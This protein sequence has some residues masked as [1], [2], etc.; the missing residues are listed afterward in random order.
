MVQ[1]FVFSTQSGEGQAEVWLNATGPESD[2]YRVDSL[3]FKSKASAPKGDIDIA[4]GFVLAEDLLIGTEFVKRLDDGQLRIRTWEEAL[5]GADDATRR[6]RVNSLTNLRSTLAKLPL[7]H[8][9]STSNSVTADFLGIRSIAGVAT[10][11][12]LGLDVDALFLGA[13]N[14]ETPF[15]RAYGSAAFAAGFTSPFAGGGL[16]ATVVLE[17]ELTRRAALNLVPRIDVPTAAHLG[18][19]WPRIALPSF[20]LDKVDLSGIGQLFTLPL[21]S[22][23]G[24][25]SLAFVWKDPPPEIKIAVDQ[26]DGSATVA[27]SPSRNGQLVLKKSDGTAP[28]TI[29]DVTNASLTVNKNGVGFTGDVA[30][31]A[32]KRVR[33]VSQTELPSA[34]T[35]PFVVRLV[36]IDVEKAT[37]STGPGKPKLEAILSIGRCEVRARSDPSLVIAVSATIAIALDDGKLSSRL[38]KLDLVEPYP[39][40][41][42]AAAAQLIEDGAR[43]LWSLIQR[44]PIPDPKAPSLPGMPPLDGVIAVL[45]RLGEL[46]A[47]AAR[48]LAE[49][50][51]A[52]ARG[53]AGLAEAALRVIA[54]ALASLVEEI[55]KKA[56]Q[57]FESVVIE[58]RIDTAKWQLVQI[59]VTPVKHV[60]ST[61]PLTKEFL[62][63][64]LKVPYA[65]SPALVYDLDGHWLALVLQATGGEGEIT[66]STDLWLGRDNAP[67]EPASGAS[68]D[69]AAD[70]APLIEIR[71]GP[72]PNAT[73]PVKTVLALIVVDESGA[74][75]FQ[76]LVTTPGPKIASQIDDQSVDVID[77]GHLLLAT[78]IAKPATLTKGDCVITPKFNTQRVLSIFRSPKPGADGEGQ[79]DLAD[80][81]SQYIKVTS[82]GAPA[83]DWDKKSIKIDVDVEIT[84]VEATLKTT[85]TI[86]LNFETLSARV[87]SDKI[88]VPIKKKDREFTLLGLDARIHPLDEK[89]DPDPFDALELWF[90]D[91]NPRLQ[92]ADAARIDLSYGKLSSEGRGLK[93]EVETFVVARDGIDLAA[94]IKDDPVTLA[95]VD[96]PFRFDKGSLS[97]KRSTIQAF[98]LQGHGN[99]PPTL[100]GEAKASITLNFAERD[101]RLALQACEAVLDKSAD[102]LRCEATRFTITVTKLGL[103][104]I[105]QGDYHF[106]FTLTGS[107]QFHPNGDEFSS[108]L[109]KNLANLK[110]VLDEAPLAADPRVLLQHIEFQI[111]VEPPSRTNF[112]NIFSFELRGVGFHPA[113]PAFG[114]TPA[115][116][117]SGQVNFTDFGDVVTPRFDFHKMW[118]APPEK[119]QSLPRLRFDGLGVGLRLGSAADVYGTAVAVDGS[120]PTLLAPEVAP[121]N[122]TG[123]G[124]LASGSLQIKGWASMSASMGF[125]ELEKAGAA[126]KRH[127]FFIYVQQN[128][129][130]EKIPTPIGTIYLREVGYG[131]GFRYT[132]AG[133]AAADTTTT[134][135]Q[136]VKLLDEV[137]KY[138]GDLDKVTAWSPTYDN[139]QITLALRGL[140]SL[141]TAS[142]SDSYNQTGEAELPNLALFDIVAAL[143]TD[144]T[145][146]LNIRLWVAYNYNDW[147]KARMGGDAS[148]R[149]RPSLR[150]YMY[151]S[152][153]RSEF[154]ARAVFDPN[155]PIGDHPKL[156]EPLKKAMQ[157]ARW[158]STMYVRPGLFHMEFGWPYEL[159]FNIGEE[160]GNFFLAVEG[161]TVLRFEDFAMLY[162]LAF[163][164]RGHASFS[165]DTGGD[166]GA[167]VS[168]YAAFALSAKLIAYLSLRISESMFYGEITLDLTLQFSVRMWLRTKWFSLSAGFSM[169]ITVHIAVELLLAPAGPAGRVEASISV[170][171]FGC[172]L[173]LGIGFAFGN[174]DSLAAARARVARFLSLG[175]GVD[176]PDP[177]QGAPVSR[178]LPEPSPSETAKN[179]D[180]RVNSTASQREAAAK[181]SEP[182]LSVDTE[183]VGAAF[184]P[185][186]YWAIL[187]PVAG[188][189]DG[190]QFYLVQLLP[191]GSESGDEKPGERSQFYAAPAGAGGTYE[192]RDASEYWIHDTTLQNPERAIS[193]T[194]N[195][196]FGLPGSSP[197]AA[198][199]PQ[200]DELFATGCF[201]SKGKIQGPS[202]TEE[203]YLLTDLEPI[204][205]KEET[206]PTDPEAFNRKVADAARSRADLG[207]RRKRMQQVDETRSCFIVTVGQCAEE[208]A[209]RVVVDKD[210][211]SNLDDETL[212]VGME[213]DPRAIG[214]TFIKSTSQI[215]T[216]FGEYD[217]K[218]GLPPH[219]DNFTIKTLIPLRTPAYRDATAIALLNPPERMFNVS[220][221]RLADLE[222]R[223]LPNGIQLYWDLEPAWG[224]SV[225]AYDDPEYHLKHYRIERHISGLERPPAPRI[226]TVK[227]ADMIHFQDTANGP[228]RK[229]LKSRLQFVDDLSDLPEEVRAAILPPAN[230][231]DRAHAANAPLHHPVDIGYVIVPV[232]IAGTA[233]IATPATVRIDAAKPAERSIVRAFA[234]FDYGN[235]ICE[236]GSWLPPPDTF[237]S[238]LIEEDGEPSDDATNPPKCKVAMAYRVRVC[239]ERTV[240][241]GVFGA[242][243]LSHARAEPSVPEPRTAPGANDLEFRLLPTDAPPKASVKVVVRRLP[244]Y[245]PNY[246]APDV[247][248]Q[249]DEAFIVLKDDWGKL[250]DKL[251]LNARGPIR[252]SRLYIAPEPADDDAAMGLPLVTAQWVPVQIQ[253]RIGKDTKKAPPPIDITVDHYE[254]PMEV[255]FQAVHAKNMST[256][257]GRLH[258]YHPLPCTTF[259]DFA[260]KPSDAVRLFPDGDRRTCVEVKWNARPQRLAAI[261]EDGKPIG[262]D[263]QLLASMVGGFDLFAIDATAVPEGRPAIEYATCIGRV[264]RLPQASRG[265][266]PSETGDFARVEALY[267]SATR[268][269]PGPVRQMRRGDDQSTQEKPVDTKPRA[270]WY[271][272]AESFLVW[273][274]RVLRRSVLTL[275]DEVELGRLFE[276]AR[277]TAVTLSWNNWPDKWPHSDIKS[278]KPGFVLVGSIINDRVAFKDLGQGNGC[279]LSLESLEPEGGEKMPFGV[280]VL[281]RAL[282][283]LVLT[284]DMPAAEEQDVVAKLRASDLASVELKLSATWW[285]KDLNKA[286]CIGTA[287]M[288]SQ[289]VPALHPVLADV[290]DLI[291][292]ENLQRH[293]AGAPAYRRYEPVVES[294][295]PVNAKSLTGF[296]DDTSAD[297]DPAGWGV[298]R[299]FGLAASFRLFDR[300]VGEFL[301]AAETLKQLDSVLTIV[302]PRYGKLNDALGSPFVEVMATADALAEL[303]SFHGSAPTE[304]KAN[305]HIRNNALALV[306]CS[307]RPTVRPLTRQ[308]ATGVGKWVVRYAKLFRKLRKTLG[309]DGKPL[310][311]VVASTDEVPLRPGRE[312][313]LIELLP[314]APTTGGLAGRRC[315]MLQKWDANSEGRFPSGGSETISKT[316]TFAKD[317]AA[318]SKASAATAAKG[319]GAQAANEPGLLA[320]VRL[321]ALTSE[322]RIEDLNGIFNDE[323]AIEPL[324]AVDAPADDPVL[325]GRFGDLPADW[326]AALLFGDGLE[327][328]VGPGG[329]PDYLYPA[330]RTTLDAITEILDRRD[331]QPGTPNPATIPDDAS[332]RRDLAARLIEWSRRFM[333]HGPSECIAEGQ[334]GLALAILTRP[335]PWRVAPDPSDGRLSVLLFEKD[336]YGK[337]RKYAVKPFGRYDNLAQAMYVDQDSAG[338]AARWRELSRP[339]LLHDGTFGDSK[340]PLRTHFVDAVTERTEPLA[341]PVILAARR[342][343]VA[344]QDDKKAP[345]TRDT[346][347]IVIARHSEEILADAN[348]RTDAGIAMRHVALGFWR[349][350]AAPDWERRVTGGTIDLLEPFGPFSANASAD[351]RKLEL[352]SLVLDDKG[353]IAIDNI[354]DLYE[355]HA[356]LWRGAYV[357]RVSDMPYG[358]RFHAAAHLAAG[359]TVSPSSVASVEGS[360]FQLM[361]PWTYQSPYPSSTGWQ[362][363]RIEQPSWEIVRNADTVALSVTWPLMRLVDSMLE[364]A[365]KLWL[366]ADSAPKLYRLPDPDVSYRLSIDSDDGSA[367]VAEAEFSAI[368]EPD[369]GQETSA[370]FLAQK[371]G[372]RF[373]APVIEGV[374]SAQTDSV[375]THYRISARLELAQDETKTSGRSVVFAPPVRLQ[376]IVPTDLEVDANEP[377]PWWPIAPVAIRRDSGTSIEAT[378]VPPDVEDPKPT[379]D[380][381]HPNPAPEWTRFKQYVKDVVSRYPP[382]ADGVEERSKALAKTVF[383]GLSKYAVDRLSDWKGEKSND[384]LAATTVVKLEVGAEVWLYGL[385]MPA[386]PNEGSDKF[387][388]TLDLGE[389]ADWVSPANPK[390]AL[391]A[392]ARAGIGA[393]FARVISAESDKDTKQRLA[394]INDAIITGVQRYVAAGRRAQDEIPFA[395]LTPV[396]KEVPGDPDLSHAPQLALDGPVD[397]VAQLGLGN[398][399]NRT[400]AKVDAAFDKLEAVQNAGITLEALA[401]MREKPT[402]ARSLPLLWSAQTSVLPELLGL[403]DPQPTPEAIRVLVR[404]PATVA[405]GKAFAPA[406]ASLP[407]IIDRITTGMVL[408]P[409]RRLILNAF[410]GVKKPVTAEIKRSG[411]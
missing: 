393:L 74:H 232:D 157:I 406:Q 305:E 37:V 184:G 20:S 62:G 239:T 59:V 131:F 61:D 195:T 411:S 351:R 81:L 328:I 179:A 322:A 120:I 295:P 148:W 279:E 87:E 84:I 64:R 174:A 191:R 333:E 231:V 248:D 292:Y 106:Y 396:S 410:H 409:R 136:L 339:D 325:W 404:K 77:A 118:I 67:A 385:P 254:H 208:L 102:P 381:P 144:L 316:I 13:S 336:R 259:A 210:G 278:K 167:A 337:T 194:W 226:S 313:V 300:E 270:G 273:P 256:N 5:E 125:L 320:Y 8:D 353:D 260:N 211:N 34:L 218:S 280:D 163:R 234:R 390:V 343:D 33:V 380:N 304:M 100:V 15:F 387:K 297:R 137:S 230:V 359:V 348:I 233:G 164:A 394:R 228:I 91:G 17:V 266:D 360:D 341:A 119:G 203:E 188:P 18:I 52:A 237:L 372:Q 141:T 53:L 329:G 201:L 200:L 392:T 408:G 149:Q 349:E 340:E 2:K 272:P 268:R 161:G 253:I 251:G 298:L 302:L 3:Q 130:A 355:Q 54:D 47:A 7:K 178:P 168:A 321:V 338:N 150:G 95:G 276:K 60:A 335:T 89:K 65:F 193:T 127:A 175:L 97:V 365:R 113:A 19:V 124:F 117:I 358:F 88:T 10:T 407:G 262:A 112:F 50:G 375:D 267:P 132:L 40:K 205:W 379:Q 110:I 323:T 85:L 366:G 171:A 310:P 70:N 172:G 128:D 286:V 306:Q 309:P 32:S 75:F 51:L 318:Q 319:V 257:S 311:P 107:A 246:P 357:I 134:P 377:A 277:P 258:L 101:G 63:L 326:F 199:P 225:G 108:G 330:A 92:L 82:A 214:L 317:S 235:H 398:D 135:R 291:R 147:R 24:N 242:D 301:S 11:F 169:S 397:L 46:A 238:F 346:I 123:K 56:Q 367:R 327:P 109:L 153:P 386:Q 43:Q 382:F 209:R 58:L 224:A 315:L 303:V 250:V 126:E 383:D 122:V 236:L 80:K 190:E 177:E 344:G 115:F 121:S 94:T 244:K 198:Q 72:D 142:S 384:G 403:A 1:L 133:L 207:A 156:P 361:H 368:P 376:D 221:P 146:L 182:S 240:A 90:T 285:D 4:G 49:Q 219:S 241:S 274:R 189:S 395:G 192:I 204:G 402:L 399:D 48:W 6:S 38:T 96:M 158:S 400:T 275:P 378:I 93:F 159:G 332:K 364:S 66:L 389:I 369:Q 388:V 269:L 76:K 281:R 114:G 247:E 255:R 138:Q 28:E 104:F 170:S 12:E 103:K 243:A 334:A 176:Y 212:S 166:F 155:G 22:L 57:I 116:S 16:A 312:K 9:G 265:Q 162:G 27:T 173:S 21:P 287:T 213:F 42:V 271:S 152:V 160:R 23:A 26:G 145:F 14:P 289:L 350:F 356:D 86:F 307:L 373:R 223:V 293:D 252:G 261:S 245:L 216:L 99:L 83:I 69:G 39:I 129:L 31:G 391:D 30:A 342:K 35:G 215:K 401:E 363:L 45:R 362:E 371:I 284:M 55:G 36:D 288:Q 71:A 264:Q 25:V 140:L 217:P 290:L 220:S 44:I 181:P 345:F 180:K 73:P 143:R 314:V 370:L 347:E 308:P 331:Q 229:R 296:L 78:R 299:T 227:S 151:L 98:S 283:S 29:C 352:R 41:L 186:H 249:P 263:E 405:E 154:L 202:E 105:E 197:G 79:S 68:A 294:P 187:F 111:P 324:V 222:T 206:L 139:S 183:I 374:S 196:R 185:V 354:R 165:A 282:L